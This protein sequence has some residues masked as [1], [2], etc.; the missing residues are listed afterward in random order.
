MKL[1]K[2]P[3]TSEV[4]IKPLIHYFWSLVVINYWHWRGRLGNKTE[5]VNCAM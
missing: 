4:W 1:V 5:Y 2:E 3:F